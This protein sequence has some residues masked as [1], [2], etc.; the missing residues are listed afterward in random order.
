ML[1]MLPS[2]L[3]C[4]TLYSLLCIANSD[5]INSEKFPNVAFK[6]PE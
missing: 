2:R 1:K 5:R 4:T 3:S 6:S